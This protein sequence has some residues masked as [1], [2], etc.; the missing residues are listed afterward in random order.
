MFNIESV[1]HEIKNGNQEI[2]IFLSGSGPNLYLNL[3]KDKAYLKKEISF[4]E[5]YTE[6]TAKIEVKLLKMYKNL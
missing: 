3:L 2:T 5:F 6:E 4:N 1:N